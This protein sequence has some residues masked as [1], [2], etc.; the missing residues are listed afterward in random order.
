MYRSLPNDF[1]LTR[2]A[3]ESIEIK[4]QLHKNLFIAHHIKEM[5][6]ALHFLQTTYSSKA[7]T[8]NQIKTSW[9]NNCR[10]NTSVCLLINMHKNCSWLL[11]IGCIKTQ[12]AAT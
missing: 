11:C 10:K 9:K 4:N 5:H 1:L 2:L 3:Q 7:A 8:K 6:K 12:S